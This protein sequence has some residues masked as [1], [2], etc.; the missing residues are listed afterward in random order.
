MPLTYTLWS[1]LPP[2]RR[3]RPKDEVEERELIALALE[4]IDRRV[5]FDH[6]ADILTSDRLVHEVN[7]VLSAEEEH[8]YFS[9]L[10]LE[11]YLRYGLLVPRYRLNQP[12]LRPPLPQTRGRT[13]KPRVELLPSCSIL[14]FSLDGLLEQLTIQIRSPFHR[15]EEVT[16]HDPE[17]KTVTWYVPEFSESMKNIPPP[18]R[19]PGGMIQEYPAP[20]SPDVREAKRTTPLF[21]FSQVGSVLT[22]HRAI[23]GPVNVLQLLSATPMQLIQSRTAWLAEFKERLERLGRDAK[24]RFCKN[25]ACGA[26]I[27]LSHVVYDF[28][29]GD[30]VTH[31]TEEGGVL[32]TFVTAD[33]Q[34]FAEEAIHEFMTLQGSPRSPLAPRLKPGLKLRRWVKIKRSSNDHYCS[35]ACDASAK[36]ARQ[37]VVKSARTRS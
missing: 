26:L 21:T 20:L 27:P 16:V 5:T 28:P 31:R 25:P 23:H 15:K 30:F 9:D 14:T 12:P 19:A 10:E 11:R 22:V 35:D 6:P 34:E 2:D 29:E 37:N 4:N 8:T 32:T 13:R 3:K 1:H 7:E 18:P 17:K 24:P 36:R 33:G